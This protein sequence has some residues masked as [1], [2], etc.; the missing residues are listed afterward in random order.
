MTKS[1]CNHA[2]RP[3]LAEVIQHVRSL[4]PYLPDA[5][6][7]RIARVE[8]NAAWPHC[9]ARRSAPLRRSLLWTRAGRVVSRTKGRHG[10]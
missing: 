10:R 8:L 5:V 3:T 9:G 1:A 7:R 4:K 6:V 2:P